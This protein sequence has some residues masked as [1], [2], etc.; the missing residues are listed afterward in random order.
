MAEDNES[1]A[2]AGEAANAGEP[3]P[4][5]GGTRPSPWK[6]W[7]LIAQLAVPLLALAIVIGVVAR[8]SNYGGDDSGGSVADDASG[9]YESDGICEEALPRARRI[10]RNRDP[11]PGL[12][13][14][15]QV[16]S[17]TAGQIAYSSATLANEFADEA[18]A[19]EDLTLAYQAGDRLRMRVAEQQLREAARQA[20]LVARSQG[21]RH[22]GRLAGLVVRTLDRRLSASKSG[23]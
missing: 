6:G 11:V 22:C 12:S 14:V 4:S 2:S 13:G 20:K 15:A 5:Q 1:I 19:L 3:L 17:D 16:L 18:S 10:L 7:T 9:G 23:R 21:A 8:D